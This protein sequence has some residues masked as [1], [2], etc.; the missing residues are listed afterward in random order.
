VDGLRRSRLIRSAERFAASSAAPAVDRPA[1]E[2]AFGRAREE[3]LAPVLGEVVEALGER[4]LAATIRVD[5]AE[6][7]PSI[8]LVLG[9]GRGRQND[10]VGFRVI[11]RRGRCEVLSYL[12]ASP[13]PMDLRRYADPGE[14]SRDHVEQVVV[15]AVEHLLACRAAGPR[16]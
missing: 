8:E 5:D 13:P 9:L 4:G 7:T 11:D 15:D 10:R 1:F 12:V 14:L 3:V 6:E 16:R 2:A